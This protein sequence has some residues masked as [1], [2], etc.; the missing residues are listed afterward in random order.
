[1]Y[2]FAGVT[3][4]EKYTEENGLDLN[5]LLP[6][7]R[8]FGEKV[9]KDLCAKAL[10]QNKQIEFYYASDQDMKID[11]LSYRFIAGTVPQSTF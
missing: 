7:M 5:D 10:A 11:K 8:H 3:S 1:M 9:V 4:I 2:N 6:G